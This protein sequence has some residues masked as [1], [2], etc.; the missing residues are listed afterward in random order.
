MT[1]GGSTQTAVG[2]L[3][4]MVDL[5][6]IYFDDNDGWVI[7]DPVGVSQV[8][9]NFLLFDLENSTNCI[10]DYVEIYDGNSIN[11]PSL[12]QFCNNS[13]AQYLL[14]EVQQQFF[15]MQMLVLMSRIQ[16]DLELRFSKCP[17]RH[18]V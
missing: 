5:M 16:N 11:S 8:T 10:Y 7:I 18:I 6:E 3:Y 17:A 13:Q 15:Y 2:T 12:G 4:D 1:S 14:R 9:V